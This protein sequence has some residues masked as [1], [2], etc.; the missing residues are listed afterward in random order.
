MG[1]ERHLP[2]P[3]SADP[4]FQGLVLE[5][6]AIVMSTERAAVVVTMALSRVDLVEVPRD[7]DGFAGFI[8]DGLLPTVEERV[9]DGAVEA[10]AQRLRPLVARARASDIRRREAANL[11]SGLRVRPSRRY[12]VLVGDSPRLAVAYRTLQARGDDVVLVSDG[13]GA[14]IAC[15][16]STPATLVV[17]YDMPGLGGM[18]LANLVRRMYRDAAPVVIV[19]GT[20]KGRRVDGGALQLLDAMATDADIVDALDAV[21]RRA[22]PPGREDEG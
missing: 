9:G 11:E 6:L 18:Q 2:D 5:A 10:V 21:M 16:T 12:A 22:T 19:V 3:S 4:A 17:E 1:E 20:S 8:E 7:L 15:R 14:L 13:Q